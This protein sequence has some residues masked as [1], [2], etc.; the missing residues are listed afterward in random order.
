MGY[1]ANSFLFA[2]DAGKGL[3]YNDNY[4]FSTFDQDTSGNCANKDRGGWWY[5]NCAYASLNG[6]YIT[7]GTKSS[8][9]SG[10][11]GITYREWTTYESLKS[12]EMKFRRK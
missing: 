9:N 8:Y 6:E 7:P 3:S 4:A 11:G 5:R 10:E 1:A 12:T 2:G